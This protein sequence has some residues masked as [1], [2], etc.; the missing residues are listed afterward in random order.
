[1]SGPAHVLYSYATVFYHLL[2]ILQ[3]QRLEAQNALTLTLTDLEVTFV[4]S[5]LLEGHG[6]V[7]TNAHYPME[8]M[9]SRAK[10]KAEE[11]RMKKEMFGLEQSLSR[12]EYDD[13]F[14]VQISKQFG[15]YSFFMG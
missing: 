11:F 1:M 6:K 4:T 15:G 7:I 3:V 14:K 2:D 5:Q 12:E 8:E 9:V 10:D 13:I